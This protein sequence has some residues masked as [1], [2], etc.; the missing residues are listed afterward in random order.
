V[1][2]PRVVQVLPVFRRAIADSWRSLIGWTIG[3]V[4]VLF[5]YL[6][7]FPSLGGAEMEEMI[8]NLPEEMVKTLG[9]EQI[10]TGA[11]YAQGTFFGLIGFL[12]LT[13]AAISWGSDA[14][15]G[16]EESGKLELTLAHGVGRVQYALES[17][18]A[19][20]V[21]LLW[22]AAV[23]TVLILLLNEPSELGLEPAHVVAASAALVGLTMLSAGF[24]LAVGALTGRRSIATTAGA[25]VAVLGYVF[26][27]IA[28]QSE[29]A[30][31]LRAASPYAW[32]Y[33]NTPL[34]DGADWGG[35]GLLW[36]LAV[37]LV[38]VSVVALRRR[39]ITG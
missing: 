15:A 24:A 12:L 29:D 34:L 30:E 39:D 16:A 3:V 7:L 31:P 28:N 6:P 18:L 4:G 19:V 2:K 37:L 22:L 27:A 13:I 35:L 9:Y 5:M 21:K 38:A 8:A 17:A 25:G 26:N 23:A 20:L 11:G 14:I 10:G 32:A 36:G 1:R 33:Q